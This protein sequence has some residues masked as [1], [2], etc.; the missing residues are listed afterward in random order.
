VFAVGAGDR[1]VGRTESCNYPP[2]VRKIPVV[3]G[4]ATPYLEPLLAVRPTQ[5]IET[6]LADPDIRRRLDA[7]NIA[8]VHVP[9]SRLE[10]VPEA[11][12]QIGALTGHVPQADRLAATLRA[13]IADARA[14]ALPKDRRPRVLLLLAPDT[15]ITAGSRTFISEMLELAGGRTLDTD[16]SAT[17]YRF[18]LEWLLMQN[19][20]II[21][22]LFETPTGQPYTAFENQTGWDALDAVRQRRVYVVP[23]LDVVC[24]PGPRLLEGLAE[25]KRMLDR[26]AHEHSPLPKK[27]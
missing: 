21:L 25:L 5:V 10:E 14:Q 4:F 1:L 15:P 13:G 23:N 8:T 12:R 19:P 6:V 26:D 11:L 7:L 16:A 20:D 22:C 9:C 18:S 17:Y 3:G 27:P 24:R 2:E